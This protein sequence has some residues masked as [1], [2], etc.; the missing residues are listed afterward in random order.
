MRLSVTLHFRFPEGS[1]VV[2]FQGEAIEEA[3]ARFRGGVVG[4]HFPIHSIHM[5]SGAH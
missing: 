3:F 2:V 1:E 4:R 5:A